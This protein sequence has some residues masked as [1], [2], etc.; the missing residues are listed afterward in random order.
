MPDGD[1]P[2]RRRL[3]IGDRRVARAAGVVDELL[4]IPLAG[5]DL[6][7]VD[8]P[9]VAE[10]VAVHTL[11]SITVVSSVYEFVAKS[12]VVAMTVPMSSASAT[13]HH[14]SRMRSRTSSFSTP[15]L[16]ASNFASISARVIGFM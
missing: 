4:R 1:P 7:E 14:A 8:V 6:V 9:D 5:R 15:E 3:D 16:A 2:R 10:V 13:A 12:A 11:S